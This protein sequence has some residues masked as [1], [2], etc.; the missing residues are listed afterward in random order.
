RFESSAIRYRRHL[1]SF[2]DNHTS[3][4]ASDLDTPHCGR[5]R[6]SSFPQTL[7]PFINQDSCCARSRSSE[8]FMNTRIRARLI[9]VVLLM[10]VAVYLFAGLP[11]RK[12]TLKEKIRLG[13]DLQ[14]GLHLILQVKTD[15]AVRSE[16]DLAVEQLRSSM[17]K[18]GIRFL[19]A[20]RIGID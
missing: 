14:G 6:P 10:I 12:A 9:V 20:S 18:N 8:A 17:R 19:E 13:L 15:D 16:T 4:R 7:T 1:S 11:P 3:T 5:H 2:F